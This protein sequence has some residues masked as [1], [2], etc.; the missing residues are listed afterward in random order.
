MRHN[1]GIAMDKKKTRLFYKYLLSYFIIFLIPFITISTIFYQTSVKN[2]REEIIKFN[3]D[4][5]EQ[6]KAFLDTRM[7]ELE[8]IANRISLDNQL[9]PYM[10]SDPYHSKQA[11]KELTSYKV[12]SAIIDE[13][14][15]YYYD[16]DQIYSPRGSSTI[17]TFIQTAYPFEDN[18][19]IK[20]KE[21]L[22]S[23]VIPVV[24][25]I[26]LITTNIKPKHLISYL[27]PIPTNSSVSHGTVAFIVKE[28][29]ITKLIDNALGDSKGNVYVY[30]A[31]NELLASANKGTKLDDQTVNKLASNDAGIIDTTINKENYSVVT[32]HS[33]VSNWTFVM[34]IP[35]D[36]F[37]VK[38]TNLKKSI[39]M[40]LL[41]I[42]F[43]GAI[44][45]IYMAI[46]QYRPIQGIVQSLRT[47]RIENTSKSK[48]KNEL[49][50]IHETIEHIH[51]DSEQ[52]QEQMKIHQPFIRDQLLSH[53]L[54]GEER[55]SADLKQML[56][57][58]NIVFKGQYYF[59]TVVSLR[60]RVHNNQSLQEREQ[61]VSLLMTV[62]FQQCVGY[63]VEL[64]HD[65]AVAIIVSLDEIESNVSQTQQK[66][67]N[68]LKQQLVS[69][70]KQIPAIGVGKIYKGI[71]LV[72]RSFIEANVA[73]EYNVLNNTNRAMYF[74]NM[75]Y[76]EA[77]LWYPQED[78]VTFVQS[79]KQGDQVVAKETLKSIMINLR[80]QD[81]SIH[82]MRAMCFELIN[83]ILKTMLELG[84]EYN[85]EITKKLVQFK[86]LEDL[87]KTIN[88]MIVHV[89]GDVEK[90]KMSHN[91]SLRDNILD[92]I[93]EEF[94]SHALSVENTAKKFQISVSYLSR[95]MKE[96][97]GSTFTQ[98]IWHLRH[99]E[100]KRQL[101]E[102]HK[103]IKELVL[104]VGYVDVANFTRKFKKE[105]GVPPG[106]YRKIYLNEGKS[107][108]D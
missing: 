1:V 61:I 18:E 10:F 53:L 64:I 86:S 80:E 42:A 88:I 11:I 21:R 25:P 103:P 81:T 13:L 62:S 26:E 90:R 46:R 8:G 14:Y 87:E 76:N 22:E 7:G 65:N 9:T 102:T 31:E 97:T 69:H 44:A 27:Y 3:T 35:T 104:E 107:P 60:D 55:H 108:H 78:Q 5:V 73:L 83:T 15:L 98:F 51:K 56:H 106:Q 33:E 17:E 96:Q 93:H 12:N 101:I 89:C 24:T 66:F 6:V 37:Y 94:C 49:E 36:Q 71:D 72:N 91:N 4:K 70:S 38:M 54:N 75:K 58:I 92:Y 79:L 68:D 16:D 52:L 29:T 23:V 82:M 40:T 19:G 77:S 20:F 84:I 34:T 2:L 100:F 63:G 50:S 59:T 85:K 41:I 30:N 67:M 47:K 48:K 39:T 43:V 28:E 45:T 74:E 57:D 32:V 99:E 95:F 105:E